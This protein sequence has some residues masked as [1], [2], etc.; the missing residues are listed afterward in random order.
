MSKWIRSIMQRTWN[1]TKIVCTIG[2]SSSDPPVVERMLEA[3]MDVARLNFSHGTHDDHARMIETLRRVSDRRRAPLAVLMDLQGPRIRIGRFRRGGA[4]L[5][6]GQP[7]TLTARDIPGDGRAV[8]TSYAS[9]SSDVHPGDIIMLAD[10]NIELVVDK[11]EG[12]DVH[13]WVLV[14]G[15]LTDHKGMNIPNVPLSVRT[16]TEKDVLDIRFGVRLG[17]D[18]I[19]LSFVRGGEDVRE[20]RRTAVEA[21]GKAGIIAK[22]ERPEALACLDAIAGCSDG[23]M[24]ARGDLGVELHPEE[25]PIAQKKIIR[26]ANEFGIP[27]ITATQ[28]LASMVESTRPTRAETSDVA[29]A[30]LD[31]TDAVMLS[32]ETAAGKH[33]VEAVMMMSKIAS[34]VE[35]ELPPWRR[36]LPAAMSGPSRVQPA[37]SEAAARL[38]EETGARWICAFT[39]SGRTALSVSRGRPKVPILGLTPDPGTFRK[40][41]LLWGVEPVL[42]DEFEDLG[43]MTRLLDD[44]LKK[45]EGAAPGDEVVI[46][47]GYPFGSD[48]H[49]NMVFIHAVR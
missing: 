7:F 37:V 36:D 2:P 31:G 5:E 27:V 40:L 44:Q 9:I 23:I 38:A 48:V 43:A 29:N 34:R 24:V 45:R 8:S 41:G 3:G 28:M 33:P 21:G 30:I 17:V 15:T 35:E 22:I 13:T 16:I 42:M 39:R 18:Y 12:E 11:I 46:V 19:A 49:S 14:G 10:G 32:E 4:V 20:A 6:K 1:R 25:V 26:K 47:A